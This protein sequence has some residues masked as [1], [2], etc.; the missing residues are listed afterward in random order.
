[1]EWFNPVECFQKKVIPFKE[2]CFQ[3]I[4]FLSLLLEFPEISA[5]FVL[6]FTYMYQCQAPHG[7]TSK[8]ECLTRLGL[9][10]IRLTLTQ[11]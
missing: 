5:P 10:K 8:K 4:P 7:D 2:G 3:G 6:K 11:G 1:M 9:I